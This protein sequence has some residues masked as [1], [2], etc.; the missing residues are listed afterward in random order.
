[1]KKIIN[2]FQIIVIIICN[3]LIV[4]FVFTMLRNIVNHGNVIG[5]IGC[6]VVITAILLYRKYNKNRK[7]RLASRVVLIF[8]GVFAVYCAVISSFMVSGMMNTPQTA[9]SA[10]TDGTYEPETVIVLGCKTINGAPS[11]MLAARLDK[12][13]EYLEENPQA[14]CIVTGGKGSDEIEAEAQTMEQYLLTKGISAER[15]YK[16]DKATNT[17]EN[18]R[19]SAEIIEKEKLPENVVIV[20]ES[21]HVY[22]GMR[23]AQKLGLNAAALPA[24]TNTPWALPSYW[25]REIFALSRDFAADL[26]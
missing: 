20:S 18:I 4:S 23:N 8:A 15:I 1:M 26:F 12:A 19:Y 17:E 7:I 25:L 2:I 16:E 14:V 13:A 24:P 21:Y 5:T 22:R 3:L 11:V 10:G 9:F 6:L